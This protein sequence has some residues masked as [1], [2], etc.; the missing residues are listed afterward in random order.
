MDFIA[1][2]VGIVLLIKG[3]DLL[4]DAAVALSLKINIPKIVIGITVVSFSTSAP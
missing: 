4:L 1:I 2:I 3:G